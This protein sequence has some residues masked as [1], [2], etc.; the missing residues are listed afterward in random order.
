MYSLSVLVLLIVASAAATPRFNTFSQNAPGDTDTEA[1]QFFHSIPEED[2]KAFLVV[3]LVL[4]LEENW[5]AFPVLL[6]YP[7]LKIPQD[8]SISQELYEKYKHV[9]TPPM[10]RRNLVT[11]VMNKFHLTP[12]EVL[13]LCL[14]SVICLPDGTCFNTGDTGDLCCPF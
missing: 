2:R 13:T 7:S 12:Q 5:P 1:N 11:W 3:S 9:D 14:K 8:L 10:F 4:G 6:R